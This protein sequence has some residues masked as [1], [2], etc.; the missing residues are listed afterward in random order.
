MARA[1]IRD[2]YG[3]RLRTPDRDRPVTRHTERVR[4][5]GDEV[6]AREAEVLALVGQHLTNAQIAATLF[7]SVRT[8]ESHVAALLR[9][10]N[11]PDRRSLARRAAV[12]RGQQRGMLPVPATPFLGRAAE[13]AELT[14][15]LTGQRLVTAVGPGG[16]GKT[17]LAIS[18][19]GDVAAGHRDGVWFV[20]LVRV[21]EPAAVIGTVAEV[22]GVPEHLA[23][24]QDGALV[25]SLAR[26]EGLL[27]LDNCEHLLD[28]VRE[29][30]D[31]IVNGCP[32]VTV[33]TTSRTRLMLPY[34]R[35]YPVP[36]LSITDDAGGDA[37][38]LFGARVAA[39]TSEATPPD[40][41]RTAALCRALDGIALAI[42]LAAS[43]YA[44]LGLDGLEAGLH[45]RLRFF[46][47]GSPTAA[48]HRSLRDTIAWSYDLLTPTDQ[49]LL[50]RVAMFAS[51]F[52]V[53]AAHHIA[54][55]SRDRAVVADGLAQLADHSLL[56]VDRG[57]PTRYRALET[58]RQYGEEQLALA[59]E[60]ATIETQLDEWCR[61][62]LRDLANVE[63]DDAWCLRFDRV[64][65]DVRAA[66]RRCAADPDRRGPAAELAAQLAGQLWLRG[67]LIEAQRRYEQAADLSPSST[68]R[69]QLLRLAA[70]A[71][72]TGYLGTDMLRLLRQSADLARSVGDLG[73]AAGD[74]AAMSLFITRAP[75]IMAQT[76]TEEEAADLLAE[77]EAVSDGSGDAEAAIALAKVSGNYRRVSV[78]QSEQAVERARAADD[79]GL[80]DAALDLLTA[81][82]LRLD[83]I[84]AAV[85][86]VR[87]REAAIASL[88]MVALH[89][90]AHSDHAQYGCEVML[91]AGNLPGASQYADRLAR[92]PFNREEGLLGLARR[93]KVDAFAGHFDAVLRDATQ[94]GNSWERL[95]EPVVPNLASSAGAVAMVHG[96][97]GHDELRARWLRLADDLNGAQPTITRQAWAPTFD[98]IVALHR[99]EFPTACD[100]L[101]IDPD[102]S[103]TWWH[104]G[105]IIYRPWYAAVWAEA[106]V[107]DERPDAHA[108]IQRARHATRAN[109]IASAM[110]ER[111]AAFAAGDRTAV[112]SLAA[113]FEALGCPYQQTR[114]GVLA[115]ML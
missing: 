20:D 54:A 93:L 56:V 36:G 51:W 14:H 48:R 33:L 96:I 89:G 49:A 1:D 115:G 17:R 83:D 87:R 73:G 65:D 8:V 6:T 78:E 26:R 58:I 53:A 113:T 91:A 19:A 32:G 76:H 71:A 64:V 104:G 114:T 106:A 94:F 88:P 39:A 9:K 18:V 112:E 95:G 45:D 90:F 38:A 97:L 11:V 50:R 72:G 82:H 3:F 34:E 110:V 30:V 102:D 100:G 27:V 107:L 67:R 21:T 105:Q 108:R 31:L 60:V 15:A 81:T 22:V 80:V 13:R 23:L 12:D 40:P 57:T 16:I 7:I 47:V 2:R 66:L 70:G 42:E 61:L 24:S 85:A 37:V 111:V 79:P 99:G 62:Q 101:A 74:L 41:A 84:P 92:L 5:S 109:P 43:R 28:G 103:D 98:A 59:G 68:D 55:P 63:P 29:C 4:I 25:A 52:D 77:A 86:T 46:T 35:V 75:G 69:V 10:L 44:T